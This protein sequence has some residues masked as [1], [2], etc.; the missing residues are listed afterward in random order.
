ML[1][2]QVKRGPA[3]AAGKRAGVAEADGGQD[4]V[5]RERC[6]D[7]E[8]SPH[9]SRCWSA[10]GRSWHQSRAASPAKTSPSVDHRDGCR[11]FT[12]PFPPPLWMSN[13]K[14]SGPRKCLGALRVVTKINRSTR[15]AIRQVI[16]EDGAD[17]HDGPAG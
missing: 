17:P 2:A 3:L 14:L 9:L 12:G 1:P 4:G 10:A 11:C 8:A 15:K 6:H 16:I 7:S 13:M 5:R